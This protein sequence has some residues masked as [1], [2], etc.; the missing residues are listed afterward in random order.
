MEYR[1]V[2]VGELADLLHPSASKWKALAML[3]A[4][5]DGSRTGIQPGVSAIAGY[6]AAKSVWEELEPKWLAELD[7]YK[8]ER[9]HRSE[10][11][12]WLGR[13]RGEECIRVFAKLIEP[14]SHDMVWSA[15]IDDDWNALDKPP[16]FANRFPS[17]L[18]FCFEHVIWQ[19]SAWGKVNAAGELIAPVFDDDMSPSAAN[20]IYEEYKASALHPNLIAS[21]TWASSGVHRMIET[22]DLAAGELQQSWFDR[23]FPKDTSRSELQRLAETKPQFHAAIS[24]K[25]YSDSG[26]WALDSLQRAVVDL[27]ERGDAFV[28][29]SATGGQVIP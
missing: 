19:L 26:L 10:V 16:A 17:V 9:F 3:R 24:G 29:T 4:Y 15:V 12:H 20:A 22:A 2:P 6:V 7:K 8:I 14:R 21:I 1:N 23:E 27:E 11:R 5:F 25:S 18:H 28:F 13:E